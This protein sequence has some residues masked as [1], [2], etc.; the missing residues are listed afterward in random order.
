M[1]STRS[2]AGAGRGS[3]GE[4]QAPPADSAV[5]WDRHQAAEEPVPELGLPPAHQPAEAFS[6]GEILVCFPQE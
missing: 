6:A 4:Q 3:G 2:H 5:V 1:L